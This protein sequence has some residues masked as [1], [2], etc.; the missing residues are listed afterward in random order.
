[1]NSQPT[2]DAVAF[3]RLHQDGRSTTLS[4]GLN[5]SELREGQLLFEVQCP[6]GARV[7]FDDQ[8]L[9]VVWTSDGSA[10]YG[11]LDLTNR[12]GFH[13]FSVS[14]PRESVAFDIR[15]RTAKVTHAEIESMARV[16]SG[17]VF[18][19]KRQFVYT[20]ATG[21]RRT[22]PMPE[23]AFGWLRDRLPELV[24]IVRAIDARPATETRQQFT[25]SHQARGVSVPRTLRLLRETPGLLESIPGGPLEVNDQRYW[26]AAV[27]VRER[28][29]EP[30]RIE[31]MQLAHFLARAAHLLAGL[32]GIVPADL[33]TTVLVWEAEIRAVRSTS[34]VRRHDVPNAQAAWTPLPTELQKTEQRYRR[35]RELHSEFLQDIDVADYSSD[36]VRANIRDV[37]EIYQTFAAHM[38]GR[39]FGLTYVSS[40]GDLRDRRSDGVSMYSDKYELFYDCRPPAKVISTWRDDTIRPADERPDIVLRRRA[41][42]AVAVLDAKFRVDRQGVARAEDLFEMQGYLNSFAIRAG[43]IV[44]PGTSPVPRL[45]EG[46]GMLLVELPLRALFFDEDQEGALDNLSAGILRLFVAPERL[47]S[48]PAIVTFTV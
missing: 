31:H 3:I 27:V 12:V 35:V 36:S 29:R 24:R 2:H 8:P 16:V 17:Q 33:R 9:P 32:R 38:V 42:G 20:D 43:G 1:M 47:R 18:S 11:Q 26:P 48:V 22:V 7:L 13:R 15:T 34:I 5:D 21:R 23:I 6:V 4:P 45:L 30:A 39:A 40:R 28:N 46:R 14:T 41:D 10:G 25:T 37:W 44:F 19:F